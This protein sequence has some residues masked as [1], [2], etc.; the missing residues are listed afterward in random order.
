MIVNSHQSATDLQFSRSYVLSFKERTE[1]PEEKT[2][3]KRKLEEIQS[4]ENP[5]DPPSQPQNVPAWG[6]FARSTQAADTSMSKIDNS[7]GSQFKKSTLTADNPTGGSQNT[8]MT[9][10]ASASANDGA[11]QKTKIGNVPKGFFAARSNML[12]ENRDEPPSELSEPPKKKSKLREN[13]EK[14]MK[15]TSESKFGM[16][17][18]GDRRKEQEDYYEKMRSRNFGGMGGRRGF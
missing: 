8:K 7:G 15:E 5:R 18:G 13:L 11:V 1:V 4:P 9:G 3:R 2:S 12:A 14:R 17:Q 6:N 16:L 10:F